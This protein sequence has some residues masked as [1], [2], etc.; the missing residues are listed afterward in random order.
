HLLALPDDEGRTLDL[1]DPGVAHRK[2]TSVGADFFGWSDGGRTLHWAVG[3]TWYRR[4]LAGVRTQPADAP[5]ADADDPRDGV[6]GVQAFAAVVE[7][8]GDT[9]RG[10]LLLRGATVLTM[11]GDEAV[12]DA[13]LL[14]VDDRIAAVGPR[15]S[16]ALPEGV[17]IREVPGR[18]I[19][20]GLIDTHTHVADIRRDVLDFDS[21]GPL[22][23]LAYGV[24]TVFDPSALSI[25]MLAYQDAI[26]AGL[27]PGARIYST[28][29]AIFS[30]NEFR[31]YGEV[32]A[33]LSR[34][35]DHYRLGNIK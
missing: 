32:R 35:R 2:L 3:S 33:V 17:A 30:F 28:G 27:M 23:N 18:Y 5:S 22:A 21:W 12:A 16:V 26:E 11:R 7:R 20:P 29:P 15:G 25:D 1:A 14:V 6:D 8:R 19:I 31:S 34:Y 10:A 24:T 9:P 4:P 13:D